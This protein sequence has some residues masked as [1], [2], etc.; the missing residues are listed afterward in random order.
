MQD[1]LL[2]IYTS[3]PASALAAADWYRDIAARD[4]ES[5]AAETD[6]PFRT[7]A[8]AMAILS[9]GPQ[10]AVNVS[11][12]RRFCQWAAVGP[13]S[14]PVPSASTYGPN[15]EKAARMLAR[16]TSPNGGDPSEFVS[17]PKV[18]AFWR[19]I[20]G[21]LEHVTLDRH[22]VRPISKSGK[23]MPTGKVERARMED[24]YRRAAAKVGLHPA[25]FQAVIWVAVRGAA[26]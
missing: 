10:Y 25:E 19:N 21:D 4:C 1:R 7:V 5:I 16:C 15:R 2:R 20:C 24:A 8:A 9:P 6:I 18:T 14:L 3:A 26:E 23:D 12:T 22:A 11:D 13:F 17:G